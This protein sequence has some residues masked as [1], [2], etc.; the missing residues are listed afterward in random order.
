MPTPGTSDFPICASCASPPAPLTCYLSWV[1]S[2][3]V[4]E[5][6]EL[7]RYAMRVLGSRF[8]PSVVA[9]QLHVTE[10]LKN[11]LMREN[12][13]VCTACRSECLGRRTSTR[14]VCR[15]DEAMRLTS[16]LRKL[17]GLKSLSKEW[18]VLFLLHRL[19]GTPS[20]LAYQAHAAPLSAVNFGRPS[21]SKLP[22][23]FYSEGLERVHDPAG[24]AADRAKA[25]SAEARR[26]RLGH[27]AAAAGSA[28]AAAAGAPGLGGRPGFSEYKQAV[29]TSFEL[30]EPALIRDIIY[31][32]QVMRA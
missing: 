19:A 7:H 4:C 15:T 32:M 30:G 6:S 21:N 28:S 9:D 18:A 20:Q 27:Q 5:C 2:L 11:R 13:F 10:L 26:A 24:P 14:A 3:I 8:E 12:R 1:L 16:L 25:A 29:N 31:V 23:A 22:D 17:S